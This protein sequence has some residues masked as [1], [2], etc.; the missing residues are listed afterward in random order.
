MKEQK[1][2]GETG[3][4]GQKEE[5][6]V[7]GE[8][9]SGM[10]KLPG[11]R[12]LRE[13]TEAYFTGCEAQHRVPNLTGLSLALGLSG[14]QELEGVLKREEHPGKRRTLERAVSRIE[15]ETIQAAYR[16]E[17]AAGAR[18][19]LQNGFGYADR[20]EEL[21]EVIEVNIIEE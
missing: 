21:P 15:E 14:R 12:R 3:D 7:Q 11:E 13:K 18:F 20:E 10:K 5:R 16:R 1:Q 4:R 2:A 6:K 17:T 9:N 8:K 19:L